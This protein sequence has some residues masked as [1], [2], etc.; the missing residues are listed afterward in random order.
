MGRLRDCGSLASGVCPLVGVAG[1]E[2][3]ACSLGGGAE[4]WAVWWAGLCLCA[5]VA[6]GGLQVACLLL[7]G[8]ASQAS[9]SARGVPAPV[10]T[11]CGVGPGLGARS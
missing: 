4:S 10:P 5:A 8:A 7:G 3:G 6:S 9:C 1:P 11:G 2:A